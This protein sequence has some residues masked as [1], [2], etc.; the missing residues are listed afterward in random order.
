MIHELLCKIGRAHP[1]ALVYDATVA[2]KSHT[3][4]RKAAAN[5][6]LNN[7]REHSPV[8]VEQALTVSRELIRVAI[9]WHEMWHEGLEEASR[10]WFGQQNVE[11]MLATLAPLHEMMARGPSTLREV[12][13]LHNYGRDLEEGAEWCQRYQQTGNDSDLNQAWDLYCNVF[14]KINKQLNSLTD[15][16][17]QYVSPC[18]LSC[19]NL[20]LAV[21]GTYLDERHR[22]VDPVVKIASFVPSLTVIGSKQR[23][24]K[25]QIKGSD[26][27][28]YVFLL[29]GHEDL[30]QDKR[31][32]QLFGLVNTLLANDRVTAKKDLQIRGYSVIPL[33][34]NSGL[35][36]WMQHCDTLH[37]LIKGYRDTRKI[38][39]NIEH[40]LMLQM[41]P[42]YQVKLGF[43]LGLFVLFFV[44]YF[45]G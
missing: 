16:E 20:E 2:S 44:L 29:K 17:L 13:F 35:I 19:T 5:K 37:S 8:L 30:R 12:A 14:R 1:R 6:I 45:F 26:G 11:G 41:A 10:L 38:L 36:Q 42:D 21:P 31:V 23:P 27:T 34:P 32:M 43:F 9:L 24:R 39:L 15:L 28:D 40:R 18:L 33:A 25:L 4:Q 22:P 7:M 3:K